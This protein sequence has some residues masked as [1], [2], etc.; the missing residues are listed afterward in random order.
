M[1]QAPST[2]WAAG[3]KASAK[4]ATT[5]R[6][7]KKAVRRHAPQRAPASEFGPADILDD[8]GQ[9]LHG[10]A[11]FYGHGFQGRKTSTG[12]RYDVKQFSAASNRFPLGSLV[13][14]RR[15]DND[16]CAI[17][18]INDRMHTAHRKR[19]IDVSHA[20][21]EYLGMLRAGVVL[22]RVAPLKSTAS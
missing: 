22:V 3:K 11:S 10:Q 7:A 9:G 2:V 5:A 18:K 20:V 16:R 19:V 21:A 8:D 17:V 13:A 15:L 1:C 6:Q 4:P 12:E 14:V